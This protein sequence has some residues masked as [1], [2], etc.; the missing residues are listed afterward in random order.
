MPMFVAHAYL[1][2]DGVIVIF[3]NV[4]NDNQRELNVCLNQAQMIIIKIIY[5]ININDNLINSNN[6]RQ[7]I[8][9]LSIKVYKKNYL[10]VFLTCFYLI[11]KAKFFFCIHYC[12]KIKWPY[13]TS[14]KF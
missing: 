12:P 1:S 13:K 3:S 2:N 5:Y 6:L 11:C 4:Y 14:T 8:K 10:N 9:I 7:T